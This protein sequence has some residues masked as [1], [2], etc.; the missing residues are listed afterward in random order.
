MLLLALQGRPNAT[1]CHNH[2]THPLADAHS[3]LVNEKDPWVAG[4]MATPAAAI[5]GHATVCLAV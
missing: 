3:A 4:Y 5:Q 2:A 1:R